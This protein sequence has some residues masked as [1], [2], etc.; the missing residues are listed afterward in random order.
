MDNPNPIYYKDLITP[1]DSITKL[2][3]QLD[4]LVSKY[5]GAKSKI[6]GAAADVAKGLQGVS[7]A[8]EEQ[9]KA[10]ELATQQTE[11]LEQEY[12]A[13]FA[14]Q[15]EAKKESLELTAA[16]KEETQVTKLLQQINVSAAG[17]YNK[18]SAQYRLN[19]IRLNEMSAE[20][21]KATEAGR[22]LE[23]E[24]NAIYEEMK[25]LQEATGKH[26]LNVGNYA[27]A[28]KGL[29]T[30]LM[31]LTQQM[32]YL[33]TQGMQNSEEYQQMAARA[34]VLRDAMND[35]RREIQGIA[36]D[37]QQLNSISAAASA[38][39]G[40][41]AAI[42]GTMAAFGATSE[43]ATEAQKKLGA[44]IGILSGLTIVQNQ[45]QKESNLMVGIGNIQRKAATAA[46]NMETAAKSK[47]IVV[48]KA[49]TIAQSMFNKVAN[50]NPYVLLAIALITVVGAVIALAA[51]NDK[52]A[53]SQKRLNEQ[54]AVEL[55]Y[56]E[57]RAQS[58]TR[59]NNERIQELNNE[60]AVAKARGASTKEIQAIEDKIYEERIKAHQKLTEMYSDEVENLDENRTKLEYFENQLYLLQK[61][62]AEGK[63]HLII[64]ADMDG[65]MERVKIDKAIEAIQGQ[66]DNYGKKV[67]IATEL[68]TEGTTI[69]TERQEQV[70]ARSR[71]GGSTRAQRAK[72]ELDAVRKEEDMRLALIQ[73]SYSRESEILRVA[74]ERE[75]EDI[76]TRLK[77]ERNL[78]AKAKEALNK[79][80]ELLEAQYLQDVE[81][82]QR[83]FAARELAARRETEDMRIAL[84]E[85]G[86]DKQRTVLTLNYARE[87]EDLNNRL[88]TE[89]DLTAAQV[90]EINEQ[91]LLLGDKYRQDLAKLNAKINADRLDA[92][93]AGIQLRL[94]AAQEGSQEFVD[95]SIAQMEKQRE[96]ELAAN[97]Q[98]AEDVRQS[99]ADIN[100][101]WDAAILKQTAEL[102][103]KRGLMI[104]DGE[105]ELAE[106][107][108]NLV[109]RN[110]RQRT[111]FELQ[112]ER[113]RLKRI[114]E[115]DAE[116]GYQLTEQQRETMENTIKAI[117]REAKKMPYNNLYELLGIGLDN[118]QQSA[119]NTAIDSVKESLSSLVDSWTQVADAAVDAADKQV[120]AAKTALEA[121][122]E[123][124]AA[125]YANAV[126]DAQKRL[127]LARSEQQKALKEKERAQ[128]AQQAIDSVTQSSSLVTASANLWS[129][130]SAIPGAG[131]ALALAAIATMWTSFAYSKV[132]A[133]QVT[134]QTEKYGEG[135]V[136]L[137]QGG[138]H[139]SGHDID[140]G[141]K[142]DGTR[143]RA[144]GGEFFAIINKRNSRRYRA[145]IPDVINSLNN[146]TFAARY[147]RANARMAGY[148]VGILGAGGTDVS[149][150]E[151]DVAAIRR[152]G[153]REQYVDG[154]GNTVIRYKNLTRKIYKN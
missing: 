136:E 23:Q 84:M 131:P 86:A 124:R 60:L 127:D 113:E 39:G 20:E 65:K 78:T 152:Q 125:G 29:K 96:I 95:L 81:K 4:E 61:A 12:R 119:L 11:K 49:A 150:L 133:A 118:D 120:D 141:T 44:S 14:A 77:T 142:P 36:S 22:A 5:E 31:S 38:A 92:E 42:T 105:Q 148:A 63:H 83:D 59:E 135:V 35:T 33:K 16:K 6:Q 48:T 154:D 100:A 55:D 46:T 90:D 1:D 69:E 37:T 8:S 50:A 106:S 57:K 115:L 147:Q 9:R 82:L 103:Q 88:A 7:G 121:E 123:A 99:E 110:E 18:L 114:L 97:A 72:A 85:D 74:H 43:G 151:R 149:A 30:E 56:M 129:S 130:L 64:D 101:K 116:A 71:S 66:I 19:K 21:R 34:G 94:A 91:L 70:A 27:D 26:Q 41:L 54:T 25:R 73:D 40:G 76:K 45:L 143:R 117:E 137:L 128:K 89:K 87:I 75:I 3:G 28:A 79:Q 15:L 80:L 93:L 108:F 51:A 58:R 126:E 145:V 68:E 144:E 62:Q 10:I 98:L 52:A 104:L 111:R 13:I 132:K 153:D 140:L 53:K 32:A 47:N 17:S 139:A 122:I 102:I 109:D 107:R 24:T 67:K 112:M 134:K 146:G 138:S 2:I